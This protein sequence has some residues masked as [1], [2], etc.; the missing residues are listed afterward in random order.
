MSVLEFIRK[1][2][3]WIV[4]LIGLTLVIFV[5]EDALTSGKFFFGGGDNTVAII[6]G[7][8]VDY[9]KFNPQIQT[10]LEREKASMGTESLGDSAQNMVMQAT[11]KNMIFHALLD[12]EFKKLG[13]NVPDSEVVSLMLGPNPAPD[14][15]RMFSDGHGGLNKQFV[16]KRTGGLDMSMVIRYVKQMNEQD[17]ARWELTEDKIKEDDLRAKYFYLLL[18]GICVPDAMAKQDN[19]DATKTYDISYVLKRYTDIPDNS[20]TVTDQDLKDYYNAHIYEYYSQ[21]EIRKV[22][23]VTFAANPTDI[24]MKNIKINVDSMY[25]HFK[26]EKPSEDSSFVIGTDAGTFDYHYHKAGDL[27]A[28]I[29]S[30][31]THS[32]VGDIYGPYQEDGKYKIAKLTGIAE[33]PDSIKYSQIFIPAPNNDFDKV[34]PFADS[35]KNVAT[36]ENFAQLAKDNSKD[37]ESSAKGGDMGWVSRGKGAEFPADLEHQT[38]FGKVGNVIQLKLQQGFLILCVMEQSER[39]TNYQVGIAMKN[40]EPSDSTQKAVFAQASDFEGKNHTGD[41]FEKAV[42][43]MN[44][45]VID[46][47]ENE[48][49]IAGFQTPKEFIKWTYTQKEGDVS[50][51]I[52]VGDNKNVV[53][54]IMQVTKMGTIPL[55]Q[56]KEQVKAQVLKEK[57]AEKVI[58]DMKAAG[59]NMAAVA[60]KTG[61]KV[62]TAKGLTFDSYSLPTLGREDAVIG[63][64][65]AMNTGT[66]S[67]P[68]KG[69]QGVYVIRVENTYY[70]N[71]MDFHITQMR[72]VESKRNTAANEAYNALEKKA[73]VV[74]HFGRYY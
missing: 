33:L 11:Y 3:K 44:R 68:I 67:Q 39:H 65:S 41:L 18:N 50:D 48:A 17:Q 32:K 6:N 71:K 20:V 52:P 62:D 25:A 55:E 64:M 42:G 51:V 35:I 60:Q 2:I 14:I 47:S 59:N 21:Q 1:Y 27:P 69:E 4:G 57:K 9:I 58:A 53:A 74:S 12:P 49:S 54:H 24:D 36:P 63:T 40:I 5:G 30:I 15:Y 72:E 13:V 29:D 10:A 46:L 7:K 19:D 38:F 8:K 61:S 43:Q 28:T 37:P 34:K 31:M 70:A 56:V 16:D 73:G 45:R 23:Y 66:V 26:N 22:D